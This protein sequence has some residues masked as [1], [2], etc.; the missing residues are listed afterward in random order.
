MNRRAEVATAHHTLWAMVAA[1]LSEDKR[2]L[3]TL[4]RELTAAQLRDI[5]EAGAIVT[6]DRISDDLTP[7]CALATV[8]ELLAA[9]YEGDDR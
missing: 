1:V 7:D 4:T 3:K 8:R 9:N 5:A 6:A 2:G